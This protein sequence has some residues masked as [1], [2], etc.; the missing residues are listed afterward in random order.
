MELRSIH[1]ADY[2]KVEAATTFGKPARLEWLP[3]KS[4]VV[5]P[6]YQREITSQGR[7]NVIRIAERF[8]WSMFAPVIV[9]SIGSNKFAIV[10]G[11]HRTT[12]AALCGIERV[13]CCI[14]EA[15]RGEQAAAFK[16]INANITRMHTTSLYRAAVAAG[17]ENAL[18]L[19]R[20]CRAAGVMIAR[21]PIAATALKPGET[22]A[23]QSIRKTLERFGPALT[24]LTL[25]LIANAAGGLAG[26][27]RQQAIVGTAE[28]LSDHP[29][30]RTNEDRLTAAFSDLDIP[31]MLMDAFEQSA[32]RRGVSP[33]NMFA[34]ALL[35]ELT[36]TL[37]KGKAA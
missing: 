26:A 6:E 4:L 3:I 37:G 17:E 2:A 35:E 18:A 11:Q 20:I 28:V 13:P 24:I 23:I 29:E 16:A 8:N 14:I 32:K 22:M 21:Y 12:A 33:T 9:S 1:T 7:K 25:K 19:E 36:E 5:D 31:V 34:A 10:D 30:W 27:L 15:K